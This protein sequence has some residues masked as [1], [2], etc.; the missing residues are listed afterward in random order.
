[1]DGTPNK[2]SP[3]NMEVDLLITIVDYQERLTFQVVNLGGKQKLILGLLWLK[4]HN[5]TI[6]WIKWTINFERCVLTHS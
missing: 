6:N 5:L 2:G 3:I 1:M 4:A